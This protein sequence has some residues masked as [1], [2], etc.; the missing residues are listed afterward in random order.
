M[1][2]LILTLLL[3]ILGNAALYAQPDED[4]LRGL[5][6]LQLNGVFLRLNGP[7]DVS[8]SAG[9]DGFA[10][11]P[12]IRNIDTL[13]I[14]G[15]VAMHFGIKVPFIRRDGWSMGMMA[16]LGLGYATNFKAAEALSSIYFD[17]P[18]YLYFRIDGSNVAVSFLAGYKYVYCPIPYHASLLGAEV[19][20]GGKTS[21]RL[22]SMVLPYR[23]WGLKTNGDLFPMV[24][25]RDVGLSYV[26]S[27]GGK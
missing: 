19:H 4:R 1:K 10:S 27:F 14:A 6:D 17:F 24:S 25:I 20:L 2:H 22:Q 23:Y 3:A 8:N 5:G 12:V 9:A 13:G 7:Y 11:A 26:L 18:Q 15:G 16:N 21:I